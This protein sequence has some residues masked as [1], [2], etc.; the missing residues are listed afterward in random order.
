MDDLG[1]LDDP[2]DCLGERGSVGGLFPNRRLAAKSSAPS[3]QPWKKGRCRGKSDQAK[4]LMT[5]TH[6]YFN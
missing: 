4:Q 5:F 6:T 1:S 3:I 2:N